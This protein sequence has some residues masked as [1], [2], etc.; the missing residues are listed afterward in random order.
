MGAEMADT[1]IVITMVTDTDALL[2]IAVD[3]GM[4]AAL[5]LD[6]IWGQMST[7][8]VAGIDRLATTVET[9]RPDVTLIDAPVSQA[10]GQ[11]EMEPS[12]GGVET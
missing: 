1:A 2:S 3:Q 11:Q 7:I 4:L 6:A 10:L 8:G 5:G 12:P 9:E